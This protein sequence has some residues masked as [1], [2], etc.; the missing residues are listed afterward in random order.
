MPDEGVL[1]STEM[2]HLTAVM[3]PL[4]INVWMLVLTI[5]YVL[6][7][8]N[9]VYCVTSLQLVSVAALAY[10]TAFSRNVC[11]GN[12]AWYITI[13]ASE[14]NIK[15]MKM[16]EEQDPY[17]PVQWIWCVI[18]KTNMEF[19]IYKVN[20]PNSMQRHQSIKKILIQSKY[21]CGG[22]KVNSTFH[23]ISRTNIQ[24]GNLL[25]TGYFQAINSNLRN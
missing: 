4:Q 7:I 23:L 10:S 25:E 2:L 5:H 22:P 13:C 12:I 20:L 14:R 11:S 15:T 21:L 6:T 17:G 1:H 8:Y 19:Y 3:W 16:V 18:K 9:L 24:Y